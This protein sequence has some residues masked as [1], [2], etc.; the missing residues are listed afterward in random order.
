MNE[1]FGIV[2]QA[3]TG[4][5]R[6]PSKVLLPVVCHNKTFIQFQ[7]DRLLDSGYKIV[8]AI[9]ENIENAP[10]KEHLETNKIPFFCGSE[11]DVLGRYY[12]CALSFQFKNIIRITSDCPLVDLTFLDKMICDFNE[13]SYDYYSNTTPLENSTFPDGSDIEIFSFKSLEKAHIEE[14]SKKYREHVTFQFWRTNKYKSGTYRNKDNLS[15]FRYTLDHFSDFLVINSIASYLQKKQMIG[16]VEQV[17]EYL[18]SNQEI[19]NLNK[20]H[21]AGENW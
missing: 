16:T 8:Y 19:F 3:R 1:D 13:G 4:S 17:C 21:Y 5:S 9:P 12:Q 20:N 6:L 11:S 10:L 7:Y 15:N 18:S 2:V 14:S